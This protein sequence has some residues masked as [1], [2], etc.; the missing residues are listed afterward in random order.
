VIRARRQLLRRLCSVPLLVTALALAGCADTNNN[1]AP[2][3]PGY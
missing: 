3:Q 2:K 1:A